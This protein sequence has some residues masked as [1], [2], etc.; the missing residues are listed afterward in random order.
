MLDLVVAEDLAAAIRENTAQLSR[1]AD[2]LERWAQRE[3][4]PPAYGKRGD[5][6]LSPVGQPVEE[7]GTKAFRPRTDAEILAAQLHEEQELDPQLEDML[8]RGE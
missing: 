6:G 1:V 7:L 5:G 4:L 2:V 8:R 3:G